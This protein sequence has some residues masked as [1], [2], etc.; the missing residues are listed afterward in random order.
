MEGRYMWAETDKALSHP[1][2]Q[3]PNK[4][5][6]NEKNPIFIETPAVLSLAQL[7]PSLVFSFVIINFS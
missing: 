6:L 5:F 3:K 1:Q 4:Y 7:S 2:P